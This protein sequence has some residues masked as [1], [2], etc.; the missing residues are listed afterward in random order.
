MPVILDE[1]KIKL[2][3]DPKIKEPNLLKQLLMPYQD[4]MIYYKVS[5]KVNNSKIDDDSL[6]KKKD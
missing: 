6:I 2:W 5:D 1:E 4:K 3:L